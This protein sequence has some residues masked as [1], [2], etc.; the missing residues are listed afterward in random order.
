MGVVWLGRQAKIL[1]SAPLNKDETS[2][3]VNEL[4]VCYQVNY[5]VVIY[6]V[7]LDYQHQ[8][9]I[10][11]ALVQPQPPESLDYIVVSDYDPSKIVRNHAKYGTGRRRKKIIRKR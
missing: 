11:F 4:S 5:V 1:G 8:V 6:W 3:D 7:K 2:E 9:T 10:V